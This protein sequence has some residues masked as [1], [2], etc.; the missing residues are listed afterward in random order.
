MGLSISPVSNLLAAAA[1]PFSTPPAGRPS[2]EAI[3][4]SLNPKTGQG[5]D[6][7]PRP[8][9]VQRA[10]PVTG[11]K[12]LVRDPPSACVTTLA[13]GMQIGWFTRDHFITL[14]HAIRHGQRDEPRDTFAMLHR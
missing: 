4:R 12:I 7:H 13:C 5:A 10:C 6:R 1:A 3:Q 9:D 2:S 11:V 14:F 8:D